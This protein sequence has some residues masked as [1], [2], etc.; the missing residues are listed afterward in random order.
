ML[1]L[2]GLLLVLFLLLVGFYL[3]A[4]F[5]GRKGNNLPEKIRASGLPFSSS[6]PAQQKIAVQLRDL[7]QV[8][9]EPPKEGQTKKIS[10][11]LSQL[12]LGIPASRPE[13]QSKTAGALS[14][15]SGRKSRA[16]SILGSEIALYYGRSEKW[17][18]NRRRI[19]PHRPYKG[20]K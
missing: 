7:A 11:M 6:P 12:D 2:L 9:V 19:L 8:W 15:E 18:G 1:P 3:I 4:R 14:A 17:Q 20:V 10:V 5:E 13:L 16:S